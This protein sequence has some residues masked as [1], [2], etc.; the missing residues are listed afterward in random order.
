MRQIYTTRNKLI[1]QLHNRYVLISSTVEALTPLRIRN[2]H[3]YTIDGEPEYQ[4]ALRKSDAT[5]VLQS[6]R[7][8]SSHSLPHLAQT[9]NSIQGNQILQ[10]Y[11]ICCYM[12][13]RESIRECCNLK[14]QEKYYNLPI[15]NK[16]EKKRKGNHLPIL[17]VSWPYIPHL[18]STRHQYAV[19][20][21]WYLISITA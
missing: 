17:K 2:I 14:K 8:S 9:N 16:K 3:S 21:T 7:F 18:L 4:I 6:C 13:I 5:T 20:K 1:D 10:S 15:Y 19:L 11:F 12:S